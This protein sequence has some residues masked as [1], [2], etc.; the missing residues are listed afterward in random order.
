MDYSST[1]WMWRAP[2][3]EE[4][5]SLFHGRWR[6]E[7]NALQSGIDT[8][9]KSHEHVART[10]LNETLDAALSKGPDGVGPQDGVGNL[11]VQT[12]A[13]GIGSGNLTGAPVVNQRDGQIAE[14]GTIE[15][16]LHVFLSRLHQR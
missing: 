15:L 11:V 9:A 12:L 7:G 10:D 13:S 4:V 6:S 8:P 5:L 1:W 2:L 16:C 3:A 14:A